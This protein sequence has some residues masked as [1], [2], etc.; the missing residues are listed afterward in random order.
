MSHR[1][2][3][4]LKVSGVLQGALNPTTCEI[5]L[6]EVCPTCNGSGDSDSDYGG[7]Y[8]RYCGNCNGYGVILT[9]QGRTILELVIAHLKSVDSNSLIVKSL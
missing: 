9:E 8:G 5:G 4:P 2:R 6:E 3:E 7:R 1:K